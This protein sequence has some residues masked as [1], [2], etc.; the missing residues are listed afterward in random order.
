MSKTRRIRRIRRKKHYGGENP[1]S[2]WGW[3]MGQ[4][5]NLSQQFNNALLTN[6]SQNLATAQSNDIVSNKNVNINDPKSSIIGPNLKGAM[7][8]QSG[9]K[10]RRH[11]RH[12]RRGGSISAVLSQAAVPAVL[13][14]AQQTIGRRRR[15]TSKRG[16]RSRKH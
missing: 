2:A 11:R 6:P 16:H 9:G 12:K 1:P 4:V 3:V 13:L 5:G 10:H 14:A 7:P 8:T 15:H